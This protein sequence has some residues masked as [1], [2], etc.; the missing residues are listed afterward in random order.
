M[1]AK[2]AASENHPTKINSKTLTGNAKQK[3]EEV[4]GNN[5]THCGNTYTISGNDLYAYGHS[6][7]HSLQNGDKLWLSLKCPECGYDLSAQHWDNM[8]N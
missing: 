6:N 3:F 7:G 5:W 8:T 4:V 1:D 2:K